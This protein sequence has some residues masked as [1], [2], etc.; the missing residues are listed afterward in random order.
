MPTVRTCELETFDYR[1]VR[2]LP[3][4]LQQQ[5]ART[6]D[7]YF[8][9][10]N[11]DI[12][13]G[14][15]RQAGLPAPGKDMG[16]WAARNSAGIFGQLL[17]GMARLACATD[18]QPLR[19]KALALF[20]GWLDTVAADGDVKMSLYAWEKLVC[21]LVDLHLYA[22]CEQALP[23]LA[24]TTEW[25]ARTFDRSRN[26]ANAFDFW[27]EWPADTHE[28]Y[29]LPENLYRAY[30]IC[31]DSRFKDFADIW[32]Y[33]G[34]WNQFAETCAP[35]GV[36]P[37]HAYSHVNT[38]S[39]AAMT[40]AVTGD[41]RYLRMCEN[42]YDYILRTQCYAT[43]GFG[44]EER[45]MPP[46]GSLGRSLELVGDQAEIPCG[47][48]A[49]FKLS[50]YLM[51]LTGH[52]RFGEWIETILY[53]AI[54]AALPT[55]PD[56]RTFYYA[57][58]RLST[59][60]KHYYWHAWPCCS[61]TYLQANAAYHD[62]IYFKAPGALYVNLFVPSE[63]DWNTGDNTVRLRQ[64]TD[65]P[66]SEAVNWQLYMHQP[67]TFTLGFRVPA[68][69]RGASAI[70]NGE[71][72]EIRA[73]SNGWVAI[74]REWHTG[75]HVA[76]RL[77]MDLRSAPIDPQHP[78]RVALVYGPV[79]LAMHEACCRRPLLMSAG[80]DLLSNL[81]QVGPG[82]RF[83]V[84]DT[85]PERHARFLEPLYTMEGGWPYWVYFDLGGDWLY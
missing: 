40:Y 14:F 39:S 12:L 84:T 80:A 21:G 16:G 30:V 3:G 47:S 44:P 77:P 46:D 10:P 70:V 75:D 58:Y 73:G 24:R 6:R 52:A 45:L 27:G 35:E 13:K 19:D 49:G 25:A 67:S 23:T 2:L 54:G 72:A 76:I 79:V 26:A 20:E 62:L 63:V 60:A 4:M 53:N 37:V 33:E 71:R 57:D 28:W 85:R 9:I 78:R 32:R 31:G 7:V 59:G 18:D 50:R 74:E 8:G 38:L 68:W 5:V 56:G 66:Q 15:R 83:R 65:Y 36:P 61:G 22:D 1:H 41:Q 69:C 42:A 34:F 11:D 51:T 81:V 29:T 48:W 82:P 64:D 43:G 17:S 55:Q